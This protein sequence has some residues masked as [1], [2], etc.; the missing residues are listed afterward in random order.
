VAAVLTPLTVVLPVLGEPGPTAG[1]GLGS[2]LRGP[3]QGLASNLEGRWEWARE[4]N[5]K[6]G[7]GEVTPELSHRVLCCL[8]CLC[9][10]HTLSCDSCSRKAGAEPGGVGTHFCPWQSGPQVSRAEFESPI[11]HL[12]AAALELSFLICREGA[13]PRC[14]W[15]PSHW[16]ITIQEEPAL[17][18]SPRA[19]QPP[20]NKGQPVPLSHT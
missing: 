12:A 7:L 10:L 18:C 11:V 9:T 6:E 5:G 3:C 14:S 1:S 13:R 17:T 15:D 2:T 8:F 20:A 4:W 19:G 16:P